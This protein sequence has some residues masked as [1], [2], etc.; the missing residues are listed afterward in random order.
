MLAFR[1]RQ[2]EA[3]SLVGHVARWWLT[4]KPLAQPTAEVTKWRRVV[5]AET[6]EAVV[7]RLDRGVVPDDVVPVSRHAAQ[8]RAGVALRRPEA[9]VLHRIDAFDEGDARRELDGRGAVEHE[10]DP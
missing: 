8:S 7:P 2:V 10:R 4:R 5:Q 3:E 1:R 9:R 6:L